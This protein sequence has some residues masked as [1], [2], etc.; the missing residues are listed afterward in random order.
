MLGQLNSTLNPAATLVRVQNFEAIDNIYRTFSEYEKWLYSDG[1]FSSDYSA[2]GV[3]VQYTDSDSS[4]TTSDNLV[5]R[6]NGEGF[7]EYYI[8]SGQVKNQYN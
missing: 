3:G 8:L 4:L 2:P 1:Q 5:Q 6:F 7:E